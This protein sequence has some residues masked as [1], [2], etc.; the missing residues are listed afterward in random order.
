MNQI[1]FWIEMFRETNERVHRIKKRYP[2]R[3]T[4]LNYLC[5]ESELTYMKTIFHVIFSDIHCRS[6]R[7]HP[8]HTSR[9][10]IH[11]HD[12]HRLRESR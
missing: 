9:R 4:F 5:K 2:F 11:L 12:P 10:C 8:F 3:V 1:P 6:F 7:I